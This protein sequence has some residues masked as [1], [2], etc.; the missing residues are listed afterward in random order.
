MS[1]NYIARKMTR[2]TARITSLRVG[3]PGLALVV[4]SIALIAALG[5]TSYAAFSLPTSSVGTKQLKDHAVTTKKISNGSV[6]GAKLNLAGVTIP[7]AIHANG[8][9]TAGTAANATN[10]TNATHANSANSAT[11]AASATNANNASSLGGIP[12]SGYTVRNCSSQAGAIKGWA[13][14]TNANAGFSSTFVPVA[15]YNCSGA[16]VLA[17]RLPGVGLYEVQFVNSPVTVLVA[18]VNGGASAGFVDSHANGPGD[19]VLGTRNP[20][21]ALTDGIGFAII[22]P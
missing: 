9:A 6:T 7:N 20:A 5:G 21:G 16:A 1:L 8:A 13:S 18:T 14:L 19:F 12:A 3:H 11:T 10:A 4:S 15:G 17:K 2:G 22:T